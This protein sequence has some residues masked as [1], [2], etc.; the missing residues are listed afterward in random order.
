MTTANAPDLTASQAAAALDDDEAVHLHRILA[1]YHD[2][3]AHT[4]P[5]PSK[6]H[7]HH[8]AANWLTQEAENIR[9]AQPS[10]H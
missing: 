6:K 7:Y 4:V 9:R 8:E 5:L 10:R 1:A 2:S 3:K